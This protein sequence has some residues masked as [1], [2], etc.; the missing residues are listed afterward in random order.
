M[1]LKQHT[2]TAG[3]IAGQGELVAL[4]AGRLRELGRPVVAVAFTRET[5]RDAESW[6]DDI[7]LLKLGQLGKLI[8]FFRSHDTEEVFMVGKIHKVNMFRDVRPDTRALRLW[9]H[10]RDRRD[11]TI[12]LA[13]V[14]ELEREGLPTGRI[15]RLLSGLMAPHGVVSRRSPDSRER[16]DAAFGWKI[17]KGIG[18]LD[19]GQTVVVKNRAPVAVEA[20]EGTDAT[21][22]RAGELAG[23][24][25]VVVK[26]A[27]PQQDFRFDVPTVGPETIASLAAAGASAI[28]VEAGKTLVVRQDDLVPLLKK[29]RIAFWGCR[30]SDFRET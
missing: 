24:G 18:R 29:H 6:C 10:M 5:A 28:A 21:I 23:K 30:A 11:D 22:R 3:I 8:S 19:L 16:S 14:D 15:D 9:K 4:T 20:I 26:V 7:R 27:K 17:A 12:L 13:L 2:G 25:A 1:P